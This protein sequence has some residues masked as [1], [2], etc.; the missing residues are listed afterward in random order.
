[1]KKSTR[2]ILE[3]LNSISTSRN[4]KAIIESRGMNIIESAINLISLITENYSP[5]ETAELERKFFNSI[6]CSDSEKF[7]RSLNRIQSR[8]SP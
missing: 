5:E 8:K 1:M 2:S 6:K 4:P 7:K 3:E